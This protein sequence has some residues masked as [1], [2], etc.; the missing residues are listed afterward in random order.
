MG[1]ILISEVISKKKKEVPKLLVL[2]DVDRLSFM[3]IK[4]CSAQREVNAYLVTGDDKLDNCYEMALLY[5]SILSYL[6]PYLFLF[7]L[8]YL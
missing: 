2:N 7:I 1:E 5:D 8:S 3:R 4:F 6:W